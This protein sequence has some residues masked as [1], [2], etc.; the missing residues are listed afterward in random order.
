[1]KD[2]TYTERERRER[3]NR[4][5]EG[6][7]SV[8]VGE[9]RDRDNRMTERVEWETEQRIRVER[10]KMKERKRKTVDRR[11]NS[12]TWSHNNKKKIFFKL[13]RLLECKSIKSVIS[14]HKTAEFSILKFWMYNMKIPLHFGMC[15][16]WWF[17]CNSMP[18]DGLLLICEI[19]TN[20]RW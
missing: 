9:N 15:C 5:G 7:D 14:H 8:R 12:A 4:H 13:P 2:K 16:C 17:S 3:E 10:E 1:M 6:G 18:C 11:I 20:I 19:I